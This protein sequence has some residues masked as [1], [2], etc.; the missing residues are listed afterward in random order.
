MSASCSAS[1]VESAATAAA[2]LAPERFDALHDED[3]YYDVVVVGAG[4]AGCEAA[5]ASARLGASTLLLTLSLDKIA[6]QPCNPAV[7]GPAKSTLVHEVDALGGLMGVA[8]DATAL[9]RRVLN[10][11]KGPAVWALRLQTDKRAYAAHVRGVLERTPNLHVREGTVTRLVLDSNNCVAGVTTLFG[12]TFRCK[13]VVLTTGTFMGG[14]IWVGRT[15]LA[16]GRAGE[17]A[18]EGITEQ[19]VGMGFEVG[20]LKTG[21]PPRVDARTVDFSKTEAQPG[22][23]EP[24]YF[25]FD[26]D[27]HVERPQ[28][29]C[30]LT[31]TSAATAALIRAN[32]SETPVYG[33]WVTGKG[34]RYC[35]SI[36]DK[37]VRFADKE[38]HQIFLEPEG[39]DTPELYVQ[40]FS[41]GL[42]E[43]L[44]LALLRTLPGLEAV[45]M[46]RPA[47]AVEYDFLPAY[48]CGP[49][50]QT[51]SVGGLF[52]SGQING[53]TGYEEAAA[54]GLVAGANAALLA[55]NRPL[56]V[57]PREESY[58]GTLIDDLVT[59]DLREPYR[60]LTSR[61]EWRLLLRGDNA[62]V[63]LSPVAHAA[64]LIDAR[65]WGM[66]AAKQARMAGE[67]ARLESTRVSATSA[68]SAAA[69]AAAGQAP[70]VD[71]LSLAAL[72]RRPHVAYSLLLDHGAGDAS[73]PFAE[74]EA[75][76]TDIKYAPFIERQR[77]QAATNAAKSGR[78]LP[79]SLDYSPIAT[80]SAE[81]REKLA[82]FRPATVGQA[83]R[84][85]GVSPADVTALIIH[86]ETAKRR[87]GRATVQEHA[88]VVAAQQAMRRG[89]AAAALAD[90]GVRVAA[91]A[92]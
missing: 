9:Q 17:G 63:R 6:W 40:G 4:H 64:G 70:P 27:T 85:G 13:S 7:G 76:E 49:T 69:A 58:I 57:F 82:K 74:A 81:G 79:P 42:P 73:L 11:S 67:R 36:E 20:R 1:S 43:R 21:T 83:G 3:S 75:I 16:A 10:R 62:D 25:S 44:Q 60:M 51:K 23:P 28:M 30:H 48:Q 90:E 55:A 19:L 39:R 33:G 72:L 2:P 56:L 38:S 71:T 18:T 68:V 91:P 50:L 88:A 66:H 35:P 54:Q 29:A 89:G 86:L 34:P 37:F 53:T 22:D 61:S 5:L 84:I 52:F 65:R 80:I 45:A 24:R 26:T 32:L 15:S 46:L 14:R 77:R 78:A 87:E 59:K 31:R 41:T 8:A 12:V 92:R 47:Y